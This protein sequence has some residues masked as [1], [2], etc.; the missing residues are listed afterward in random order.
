M[1]GRTLLGRTLLRATACAGAV[2]SLLAV[3]PGCLQPPAQV[4]VLVDA[5]PEVRVDSRYHHV[6]VQVFARPAPAGEPALLEEEV[7]PG[8][9]S[10]VPWPFRVVLTPAGGDAARRYEVVVTAEDPDDT[11]FVTAR[12]ISGY[13]PRE[14]RVLRILL[15]AACVDGPA[16]EDAEQT[17]R[18]GICRTALIDPGSLPRLNDPDA[19][20]EDA[21]VAPPIDAPMGFDAPSL[22]APMERDAPMLDAPALDARDIDA[23]V[24][25]DPDAVT[26]RPDAPVPSDDVFTPPVDGGVDGGPTRFSP[27][28]I[29]VVMT[30]RPFSALGSALCTTTDGAFLAAAE[31]ANDRV[32]LLPTGGPLAALGGAQVAVACRPE[33]GVVLVGS[34]GIGTGSV[35]AFVAPF[36]TASTPVVP[37]SVLLSN[38]DRF[39]AALA[40][41]RGDLVVVGAPERGLGAG[42]VYVINTAAAETTSVAASGALRMNDHFGSSVAM[43]RDGTV[44]AVGAPD[45]DGGTGGID[46]VED[47]RA[48]DS[49]AVFLFESAGWGSLTPTETRVKAPSPVIGARFGASVALDARG[50]WL[51]VGAPGAAGETGAVYVYNRPASTVPWTWVVTLT[52]SNA[53]LGDRFGHSLDW[54]DDAAILVVGAPGEDSPGRPLGMTEAGSD[55]APDTG[56]V[57]V[58]ERFSMWA[59]TFLKYEDLL[60]GG[61]L[62]FSVAVAGDGSVVYA[63]APVPP[64]TAVYAFR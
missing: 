5:E 47:E 4:I 16:C 12:A 7:T 8:L 53:G 48:T 56:A 33:G 38:D 17:C 22:D 51:A 28:R 9:E 39:G 20:P 57:Y 41:S 63:G 55:A 30:G 23:H 44:I 37:I 54:S 60:S 34:P 18:G 42:E 14:T 32:L 3:V 31:P 6:R 50:T 1:P 58:F 29:A 43:S 21:F 26:L 62:G 61:Q 46:M 2:L 36:S 24:I 49:G 35:E 25:E 27:T 40:A 10:G 15:T 19:G 11:S 59:E 45:E 52:A 13:I 64:V